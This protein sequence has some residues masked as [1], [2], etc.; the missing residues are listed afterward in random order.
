MNVRKFTAIIP[1]SEE[2][3]MLSDVPD[4]RRGHTVGLTPP[5]DADWQQHE[6]AKQLV[7]EYE[8]LRAR[9]DANDCIEYDYEDSTPSVVEPEGRSEWEWTE[10]RDEWR[11]RIGLHG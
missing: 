7:A 8:A 6:Q 3:L 11:S 9:M 4:G 10:T 1:I 5:T 2:G